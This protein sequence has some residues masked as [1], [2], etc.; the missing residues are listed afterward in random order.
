MILTATITFWVCLAAVA[1]NYV[2]YPVV[3]FIASALSQAKSDLLYLISRGSR[4][5]STPDSYLPRVAVLISA[6]NEAPVIQAKL[7]NCMQIDYPSDRLECLL[8]LD[9]PTDATAEL[10]TQLRSDSVQVFQFRVRRGKLAVLCDLARRTS[11]E[12]LVLTDANT[13][14]ERNSIRNMVRHFADA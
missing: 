5:C 1:Y 3:L 2:G 10:A 13:M 6:Y 14:L 11:A 8:G 12:I 9:A 4:R 7:T